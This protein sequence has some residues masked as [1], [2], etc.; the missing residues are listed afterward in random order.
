M[1]KGGNGAFH[2]CDAGMNITGDDACAFMRLFAFH[3]AKFSEEAV[4]LA[5][6]L[7][8]K[9]GPGLKPGLAAV[10]GEKGRHS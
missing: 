2:G 1:L 3:Y 5:F 9:L 4:A 7:P 10:G 8:F 6:F